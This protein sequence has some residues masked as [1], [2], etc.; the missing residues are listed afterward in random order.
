MFFLGEHI[1]SF[2]EKRAKSNDLGTLRAVHS[3][4]L[5]WVSQLLCLCLFFHS[6]TYLLATHLEDMPDRVWQLTWQGDLIPLVSKLII[7]FYP[8]LGENLWFCSRTI[9]CLIWGCCLYRMGIRHALYIS[10]GKSE[11]FWTVNLS[12]QT[13]FEWLVMTYNARELS[14]F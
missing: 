14:W 6:F 12:G 10:F 5:S 13:G 2:W 8:I 1:E 11:I 3:Q 7:I 4:S 9:M